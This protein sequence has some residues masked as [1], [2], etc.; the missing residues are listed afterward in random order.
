[1]ASKSWSS[2]SLLARTITPVC[3]SSRLRR[4]VVS[5]PFGEGS[6]RSIRTTSGVSSSTVAR[7]SR[8]V[9]ASP[10]TS[11]SFSSSRMLRTPRRNSVW[12]STMTTRVF[13]A[14]RSPPRR[15]SSVLIS[16]S[17][18]G[19][20]SLPL[21]IF[22]LRQSKQNAR[23]LA[24]AGL[25]VQVGPHQLGALAH[26]LEPEAAAGGGCKAHHV[27]AAAVIGDHEGVSLEADGNAARRR[28]LA[29]VLER[30]LENAKD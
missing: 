26:E 15:R 4:W 28:V 12:P 9:P 13:P 8:P 23:A 11:M 6:P 14:R 5:I 27:E 1:M 22:L 24:L 20:S 2:S 30:L 10:T 25:D 19:S 7:A 16:V 18:T 17:T 29:Y 21:G 3:G